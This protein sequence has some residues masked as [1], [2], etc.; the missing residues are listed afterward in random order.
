MAS[1]V[2]YVDE[3]LLT[4]TLMNF[5]VLYL[6][7]RLAGLA[8]SVW[9]L[10][11]AALLGFLYILILFTPSGAYLY[12]LV[13]KVLVSLLML[14]LAFGFMPWRRFLVVGLIF[15]GISLALGGVVYGVSFFFHGHPE[16]EKLTYRF[17][18]PGLL[19]TVLLAIVLGRVGTRLHRR[20]GE[21]FFH[22]PCRLWLANRSLELTALV[23]TGNQLL[24]PA[25]GYP[26][27]IVD[28]AV[29]EP[30][31]PEEFRSWLR[32]SG[33]SDPT[34]F[35]SWSWSDP[36]WLTRIRLIPFRSLGVSGGLLV[37]IKPDAVEV[38]YRGKGVKTSKV[39]VGIYGDR[40]SPEGTYQALLPPGLIE[41]LF[42]VKEGES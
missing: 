14:W 16:G 15:Y 36:R 30:H 10:L 24:D 4:N 37:G 25:S 42:R 7:G 19:A 20:V 11:L 41:P 39:V 32:E 17:F 13:G 33:S 40:L 22:V 3:L 6:T 31:L 9:R 35:A 27:M 18:L 12:N 29:L 2:V 5:L 38:W 8:F 26:V 1:C 23:D 34:S 28:Y 21:G